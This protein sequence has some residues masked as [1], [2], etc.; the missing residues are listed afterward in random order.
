MIPIQ[1]LLA[2][3]RWDPAFAQARFELG[4]YDRLAQRIVV[5]PFSQLYFPADAPGMFELIDDLGRLHTIPF[6]RVK[7]VFRNGERIWH[8][9]H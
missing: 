7:S 9:E 4:Y 3:I 1:D 6:H 5:V 8:R 2:R